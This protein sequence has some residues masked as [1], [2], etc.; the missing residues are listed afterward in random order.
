M[1]VRT[2]RAIAMRQIRSRV[3]GGGGEEPFASQL[4]PIS[5]QNALQEAVKIYNHSYHSAIGMNP[6]EVNSANYAQVLVYQ[7]EGRAKKLDKYMKSYGERN[8][9]S[10]EAALPSAQRL[11][12]GSQVRVLLTALA[13]SNQPISGGPYHTFQ[14]ESANPHF[15]TQVFP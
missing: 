1:N 14:K 13:P 2:L 8:E 11:K 7:E 12:L 9:N 5:F 6:D 10:I 15:S 3:K 4:S